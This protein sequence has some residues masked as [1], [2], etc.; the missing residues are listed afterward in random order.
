MI[1]LKYEEAAAAAKEKAMSEGKSI[2]VAATPEGWCIIAANETI[3]NPYADFLTL[4]KKVKEYRPTKEPLL[5]AIT[6]SCN[7]S[8]LPPKGVN[9]KNAVILLEWI[10]AGLKSLSSME[11]K[12]KD[13]T[14]TDY[15]KYT[16]SRYFRSPLNKLHGAIGD[17]EA[18]QHIARAVDTFSWLHLQKSKTSVKV[19][20]EIILEDLESALDIMKSMSIKNIETHCGIKWSTTGKRGRLSLY[21]WKKINDSGLYNLSYVGGQK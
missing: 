11:Y 15:A 5:E 7:K 3:T 8:P 17:K 14:Y 4:H 2:R 13:S 19:N 21:E 20:I 6:V 18:E 10:C 12:S 16:S 9:L 1:Y